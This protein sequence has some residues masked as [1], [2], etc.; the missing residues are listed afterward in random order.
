M[1]SYNRLHF[2]FVFAYNLYYID[3]DRR[4]CNKSITLILSQKY[5][6]YR[7]TPKDFK[8]TIINSKT[9]KIK[10][11]EMGKEKWEKK[12]RTSERNH[13]YVSFIGMMS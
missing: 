11:T 4:C 10:Q 8:K 3:L 2:S 1:Y 7:K 13:P 12:R 9:K 6:I 5:N